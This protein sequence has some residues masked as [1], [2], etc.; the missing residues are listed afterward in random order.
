M[1]EVQRDLPRDDVR[2]SDGDYAYRKALHSEN[3]ALAEYNRVLRIFADLNV[4]GKIPDE[5]D[6]LWRQGTG[7]ADSASR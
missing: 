6:W 2:A 5:E 3:S 1:K 4:N 7:R